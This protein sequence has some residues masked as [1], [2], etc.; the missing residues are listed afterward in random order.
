MLGLNEK[1]VKYK[2]NGSGEIDSMYICDPNDREKKYIHVLQDFSAAHYW[3]L[4][5]RSFDG[6]VTVESGAP[7]FAIPS[8]STDVDDYSIVGLGSFENDRMATAKIFTMGDNVYGEVIIKDSAAGDSITRPV[9]IVKKVIRAVNEK[10][11]TRTK[12]RLLYNGSERE[13]FV[14]Y[15]ITYRESDTTDITHYNS[16]QLISAV[17]KGDIIKIGLNY[18][19]EINAVW[20]IYKYS[21]GTFITDTNKYEPQSGALFRSSNRCALGYAYNKTDGLLKYSLTPPPYGAEPS[22]L[23]NS[24]LST[25]RIYVVD[26]DGVHTGNENDIVDYLSAGNS[27][28]KIVVHTMWADPEDIIIIK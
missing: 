23:E 26:A 16:D 19:D 10:G 22:D 24:L 3:N 5:Q 4:K 17:G 28:S 2:T 27:C 12:M 6:K 18:K 20:H 8:G 15:E 7:V 13:F 11:E 21:S 1:I 9:A 25:F 14:D